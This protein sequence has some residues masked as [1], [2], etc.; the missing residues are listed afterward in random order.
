[1]QGLWAL[2]CEVVFESK[3][4]IL[5]ILQ[6]LKTNSLK[7]PEF[8]AKIYA[9]SLCFIAFSMREMGFGEVG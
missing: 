4:N 6:N 2:L 3:I 5:T 1:M 9:F 8:Q 7:M